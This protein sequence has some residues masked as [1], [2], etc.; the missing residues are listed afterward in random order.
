MRLVRKR[1]SASHARATG[2]SVNRYEWMLLNRRMISLSLMR[3]E[4][5][6]VV[7]HNCQYRFALY[8]EL[9]AFVNH[10]SATDDKN[11]VA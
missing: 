2:E 1:E 7:I 4:G 6:G 8:V 5:L 9:L 3:D 10:F 11:V